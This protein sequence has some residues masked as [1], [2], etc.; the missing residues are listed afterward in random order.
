MRFF[1][2]SVSGNMMETASFFLNK[3][4]TS[5]MVLLGLPLISVSLLLVFSLTCNEIE[6]IVSNVI[7][8]NEKMH[9]ESLALTYER[10]L[11]ETRNQLRILASGAVQK[12]SMKKR[13]LIRQ[14]NGT[15]PYREIAYMSSVSDE[16]YVLLN[17]N[18]T[19]VE[20]P[21]NILKNTPLSPYQ[22]LEETDLKPDAVSISKPHE[23]TYNMIKQ[24]DKLQTVTVQVIRLSTPV[25]NDHFEL[26]GVLTLSLDLRILRDVLS[27]AHSTVFSSDE[28]DQDSP[29]RAFFFDYYGWILF[30]SEDVSNEELSTI[31][32]RKDSIRTGLSG[33]SGSPWYQ[34]SFRPSSEY[35]IYH[36]MVETIKQHKS[37][38][39]ML[40]KGRT[41][42]TSGQVHAECVSY[43]PVSFQTYAGAEPEVIGGIAILD[44][45]FTASQT[46]NYILKIFGICFLLALLLLSSNLWWISQKT[47]RRLKLLEQQLAERNETDSSL[48]LNL[49]PLPLELDPI[50]R[51]IDQLLFRLHQSESEH[52]NRIAESNAKKQT[53][54][55]LD[56][57]SVDLVETERIVGFSQSIVELRKQ[58]ATVAKISADILVVGET[59]TGKELVSQA[60]HDA[61]DRAKMP[62]ISINCGALDESLLMDTLFGHVKG[63][64][65][66]AKQNRKGAFVAAEGGTLLLD[67]IGN[68]TPKVQQALLRAL[69]IR[70]IRPL[71]S[72]QDIPF[73]ARIIAAT[74]ADLR[75]DGKE[76]NFRNDLYF[77][78]AVISLQTPPLR[79]RKDDI[80]ALI[81]HF[82]HSAFLLEKN[83]RTKIPLISHGALKKLM[84]YSWPGNVRELKNVITRAMAFSQ[85]DI[86]QAE[87]II[88]DTASEQPIE[89]AN[90]KVPVSKLQNNIQRVLSQLNARQQAALPI[91]MRQGSI[92]RQEY[93]NLSQDPISMRTAQYD[94]QQMVQLG[95]I[96]RQGRGPSMSYFVEGFEEKKDKK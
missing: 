2:T 49:P 54:P 77:R 27:N 93:Q 58:I 36:E 32:L 74:N 3:S 85:R 59:G 44:T 55:V 80:P 75:S 86:L 33:D 66:E 4:L 73:S 56:L 83:G 48:P 94:L 13:I 63:A 9:A 37:G 39:R 41:G 91:L 38:H 42:W 16:R 52:A 70:S 45:R 26:Q 84:D 92:T 6:N 11:I 22:T 34:S 29:T 7:A 40:P 1:T 43:A 81:V 12:E 51:Q 88:L 35:T 21:P 28:T 68:A 79:D 31:P 15:F 96:T 30:Q 14:D 62:F 65:T 17:L 78:L 5:R 20:L 72:D 60:I 69:S 64:F 50:R 18:N 76:G 82:M 24:G 95:L 46:F 57:P 90:P 71:G 10:I 23:V 67:E 89:P 19:F 8:R 87:D 47:M 53:E 61:S 25:F